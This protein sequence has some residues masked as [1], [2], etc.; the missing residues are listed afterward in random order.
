MLPSKSTAIVCPTA[1]TCWSYVILNISASASVST[2]TGLL[3]LDFARRSIWKVT[4]DAV[5]E[6]VGRK[7]EG[8]RGWLRVREAHWRWRPFMAR[9]E[10]E[11]E[12]WGRARKT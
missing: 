5:V 10:G 6:A 3:G 7:I 4:V 8:V 2:G 12:A 9:P 1:I 11:T